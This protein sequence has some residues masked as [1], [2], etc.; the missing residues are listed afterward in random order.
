M[1]QSYREATCDLARDEESCTIPP[2]L[3]DEER[4]R[5]MKEF[6]V[7]AEQLAADVDS[8][9]HLYIGGDAWE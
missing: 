4:A 9:R 2:A 1:A 6:G 8:V 3:M 7:T 5:V